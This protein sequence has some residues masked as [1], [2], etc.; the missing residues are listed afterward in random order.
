VACSDS[1]T[2]TDS[3]TGI[4]KTDDGGRRRGTGTGDGGRVPIEFSSLW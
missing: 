2:D 4:R 1:A 3:G